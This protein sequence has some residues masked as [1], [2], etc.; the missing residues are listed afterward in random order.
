MSQPEK[1]LTVV[2]NGEPFTIHA[3]DDQQIA[4]IIKEALRVAD[5]ARPTTDWEL[6]AGEGASATILD[7]KKKLRDYGITLPVTLFLN[8]TTG[9]GGDAG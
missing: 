9:G 1:S 2:V 3:N 8:L 5:Q 6:R 7:P 4:V